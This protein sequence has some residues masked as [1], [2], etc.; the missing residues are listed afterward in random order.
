[1]IESIEVTINNQ[2]YRVSSGVTL[3]E[4]A[5]QF[6]KEY[7]YPILRALVNIQMKSG[8]C[9]GEFYLFNYFS[10]PGVEQERNWG[11]KK[12]I[13]D[14]S[15]MPVFID[16]AYH[17]IKYDDKSIVVLLKDEKIKYRTFYQE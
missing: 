12:Y 7:K 17:T 5:A 4:V 8:F 3:E 2:K 1:M 16:T 10:L 9:F 15:S 14:D 13:I 11:K 6:Q